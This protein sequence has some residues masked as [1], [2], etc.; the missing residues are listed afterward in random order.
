MLEQGLLLPLN[1]R[2]AHHAHIEPTIWYV[3]KGHNDNVELTVSVDNKKNVI[4]IDHDGLLIFDRVDVVVSKG[5]LV[6]RKLK[7]DL[8]SKLLAFVDSGF[9][10]DIE[11]VSKEN[12]SYLAIYDSSF[13]YDRSKS[14]IWFLSSFLNNKKW[15][16]PL[17][18]ILRKTEY[19]GLVRYL[20]EGTTTSLNL[21]EL[22]RVYGLSYSHFRRLCRNALG[23]KVKAELCNWRMARCV[24]E[25]LEGQSDM[26]TV[27]HKYGYSSSSH[28]S[29]E[30]KQRIGKTPRD[31]CRHVEK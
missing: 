25:I 17:T 1:I 31:L 20:I 14:E 18:S 2:R 22:G 26:T 9:K 11:L 6:Y 4:K 15:M 13:L 8:L 5:A 10:S 7:I 16:I 12:F 3:E 27:A 23:V 24:L 29:S 30:V 28:F 19:Y 21:Y